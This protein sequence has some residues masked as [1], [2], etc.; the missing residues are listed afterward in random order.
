M[1]NKISSICSLSL[2]VFT[3]LKKEYEVYLSEDK[4]DF[5][6][7]LNIDNFYKV[8]NNT[9]LPPIYFIG[10]KYYLNSYYN[11]DN[12]ESLVPFLCLSSLV[13]NL[14]PLK[15]GLIE[16]ELLD[17]K[18]KYDL[19][20]KTYFKEELEIADIVSK[21]LLV[22]IPFKVIFKES[23]VDIVNYLVE[24][25]SSDIG[26]TYYNIS[27]KM[28]DIRKNTDYFSFNSNINYEEVKDYLYDFIG[29]KVR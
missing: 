23:D 16:K 24:D 7:K 26:L 27:K 6:N 17:L 4:K 25:A 2:E 5:L 21:T 10:D 9:Y 3:I 1:N 22:D 12:I 11:L 20:I 19:N 18:D 14:N 15:I 28:K 8:I 29:N 13:T